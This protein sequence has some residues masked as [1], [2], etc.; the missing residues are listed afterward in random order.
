MTTKAR[1]LRRAFYIQPS[2]QIIKPDDWRR[3]FSPTLPVIYVMKAGV[4]A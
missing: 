4:K 1:S 2:G 3:D